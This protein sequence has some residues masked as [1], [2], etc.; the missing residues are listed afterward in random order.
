LA[1]LKEKKKDLLV[2]FLDDA[3][4]VKQ[5]NEAIDIETRAVSATRLAGGLAGKAVIRVQLK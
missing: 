2:D 1:K 5:I 4:P 3:Q